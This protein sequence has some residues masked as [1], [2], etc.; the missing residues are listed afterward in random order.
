VRQL[1][2]TDLDVTIIAQ[3]DELLENPW[4]AVQGERFLANPDNALLVAFVDQQ[5][6]GFLTAHRL[7][8]L[9]A[10]QAEVLLYEIE[11]H[12]DF[13]RR[14]V[15]TALIEAIKIWA[16][17]AG[18]DELWVLTYSSNIPA[19]ALY[20]ATGGEED[21]P[22]TRMFTYTLGNADTNR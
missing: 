17:H 2:F 21:E 1:T 12:S 6:A 19:M 14:G 8:R 22:G 20:S 13:R 16:T 10:R 7:Q 3:L 15:G 5:V 11:T 18:A 9:D 4:E